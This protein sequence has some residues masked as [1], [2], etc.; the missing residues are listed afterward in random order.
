VTVRELKV[1]HRESELL[2][3]DWT[4]MRPQPLYL[5]LN[6]VAAVFEL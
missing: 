2:R 4:D 5:D 6:Q 1:T 3:L